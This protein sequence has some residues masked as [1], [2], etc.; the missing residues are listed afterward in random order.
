MPPTLPR[1]ATWSVWA[2]LLV[3]NAAGSFASGLLVTALP[4]F[5]FTQGIALGHVAFMF[6]LMAFLA[7]GIALIAGRHARALAHPIPLL[8]LM[9]LQVAAFPVYLLIDGVYGFLALTALSTAAGAATGP[10]LQYLIAASTD[11]AAR[12]SA[13]ARLGVTVSISYGLAL[14]TASA[15]LSS[16][17]RAVFAAGSLVALTA[18]LLAAGLLV[19]QGL[20][21]HPARHRALKAC[22]DLEQC[23]ARLR[24]GLERAR[25]PSPPS[26]SRRNTRLLALHTFLFYTGLGAYPIYLPILLM[27]HGLE[28]YWIGLAMASSWLVFGL[29][30]PLAG[31]VVRRVGH[32]EQI[33]VASLGLAVILEVGIATLPLWGILASWAALGVADGIGRPLTSAWMAQA[34]PPEDWGPSMGLS[35]G[36]ATAAR[37]IAPALFA[38]AMQEVGL[39]HAFL[40]AALMLSAAMWP[41]IHLMARFAPSASRPAPAILG[42]A[43]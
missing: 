23:V 5:L 34:V 10:A 37:A 27:T 15:L 9:G 4:L 11:P 14:M 2:V 24:A 40:V 39:Q 36:A 38:L 31:R 43:S 29:V 42:G 32:M 30:Q 21:R 8:V 13:Y 18:W 19:Q 6:G 28:L 16:G 7:V 33:V 3:P 41:L 25:P 12:V 20:R 1:P 26:Q 35:L 17:F 22:D